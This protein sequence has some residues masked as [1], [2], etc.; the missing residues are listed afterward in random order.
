MAPE[1]ARLGLQAFGRLKKDACND[2][3]NDPSSSSS[4]SSSVL[5]P[6]SKSPRSQHSSRTAASSSSSSSSAQVK[7]KN[8]HSGAGGLCGGGGGY[9]CRVDIWS[10]GITAYESAVGT[11]PWPRRMKLEDVSH[12]RRGESEDMRTVHVSFVQRLFVFFFFPSGPLCLYLC[13]YILVHT[14]MRLI[15]DTST[16]RRPIILEISLEKTSCVC[17]CI[18]LCTYR[19]PYIQTTFVY[20]SLCMCICICT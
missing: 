9:D 10:L 7:L 20:L 15:G 19:S 18:C 16:S 6:N 5:N 3:R 13:P 4:S 17:I 1:V 12:W 14:D 8:H 2:H 11:L